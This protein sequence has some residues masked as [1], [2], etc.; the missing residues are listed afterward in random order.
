MFAKKLWLFLGL[1]SIA[2][3]LTSCDLKGYSPPLIISERDSIINR[4]KV[5]FITNISESTLHGLQVDIKPL[6]GEAQSFIKH[7]L[8]PHKSFQVGWLEL[9]GW[10]PPANCTI[11]ITVTGYAGTLHY[12]QVKP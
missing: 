11:D 2:L 8:A 7:T 3:V 10:E 6:H 5:F 9:N 1:L 4:G 12:Q